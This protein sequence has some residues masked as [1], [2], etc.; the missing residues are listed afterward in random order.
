MGERTDYLTWKRTRKDSKDEPEEKKTKLDEV[1]D[2][3]Y[4]KKLFT[5]AQV[6]VAVIFAPN[7]Y[8]L[9]GHFA[10]MAEFFLNSQ[11]DSNIYFSPINRKNTSK[12]CWTTFTDGI[13][14]FEK[15][16]NVEL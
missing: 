11:T 14:K 5:A 13:G 9:S 2:D 6:R 15:A 10:K 12:I 1:H 3:E 8:F 7:D 16:K 4:Q